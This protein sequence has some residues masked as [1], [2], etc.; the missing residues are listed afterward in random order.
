MA[1]DVFWDRRAFDLK[2]FQNL[3]IDT[4]LGDTWTHG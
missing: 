2:F 4:I 3:C 1:V